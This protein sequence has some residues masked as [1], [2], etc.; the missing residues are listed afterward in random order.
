VAY[1]TSHIEAPGVVVQTAGSGVIQLGELAGGQSERTQQLQ[2]TSAQAGITVEL[3]ADI[4]VKIWEKFLFICAFSGV[5]ALTRLPIGQVLA[6]PETSELL[7]AVLKEGEVVARVHGIAIPDDIVERNYAT[8][9]SF[10]P[11]EMGSM[12]VDLLNGRRLE[13][14]ALNGTMIRLGNE[15]D[16][17]LPFNFA[18]YAALKPYIQGNRSL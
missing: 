4:R 6:H 18:I 3:P 9:Q 13:I 14:E 2:Q 10:G 8:I 11:Q 15:H 12:A 1:V 7:E 16:L 17:F 5:T